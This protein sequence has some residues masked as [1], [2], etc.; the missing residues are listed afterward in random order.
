MA[1]SATTEYHT[2]P[3]QMRKLGVC[4]T[5]M[6]GPHHCVRAAVYQAALLFAAAT[7]ARASPSGLGA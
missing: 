6:D 5:T 4:T 3:D 2:A 1:A 7:N